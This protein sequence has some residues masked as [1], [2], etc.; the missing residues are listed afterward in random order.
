VQVFCKRAHPLG[1]S[2]TTCSG[3]TARA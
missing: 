3:P 1:C 2:W